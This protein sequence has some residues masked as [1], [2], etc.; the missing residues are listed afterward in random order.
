MKPFALLLMIVFIFSCKNSKNKLLSKDK[1]VLDRKEKEHPGKKLMETNC[2]V[3]H[4]PTATSEDR[5]APPMVAIKKHY[6]KNNTTKEEFINSMQNWIENPTKENV[7]MFEAVKRFGL[8]PKQTF[9]DETIKVISDYMFDNEIKQP[10]WFENHYNK[11]KGKRS[12]VVNKE[13]KQ[14]ERERNSFN[15]L[16][17]NERGLKYALTTK[18]VLG[19]NLMSTIQKE[20]TLAALNFCN[21][22]AY[23]LTDSMSIIHKATI[24][25]FLINLET[26]V[27]QLM[28]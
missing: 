23:P 11:E 15:N 12:G 25:E 26:I 24:K 3:C 28:K 27:I 16:P 5:I 22:R 2:Y 17:Y 7:K 14:K 4:N 6:I 19:K 20:G 8:M 1:T 13:G 9:P 18:S 21:E 10:S